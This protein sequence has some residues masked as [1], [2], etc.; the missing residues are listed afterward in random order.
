MIGSYI[1]NYSIYRLIYAIFGLFLC[2]LL[3]GWGSMVTTLEAG[4]AVPDWPTSF[5]SY[6]PFNP[7]FS[8]PENPSLKWWEDT[9]VMVEHVHRL[10][11]ALVGLWTIGLAVWTYIADPRRWMKITAT[12]AVALVVIQGLLG[13]LR[14]LWTS[15]DLAVAHAM[16]AQIF[17]CTASILA[18]S[19]SK[20][21]F[22]HTLSENAGIDTVRVLA[23]FTAGSVLIQILLGALL[24]H[25]GA[26]IDTNFIIVH[27]LGGIIALSFIILTYS[28]IR[29]YFPFI[30]LFYAGAFWILYTAIFQIL[31]GVASLIAVKYDSG[32]NQIGFWQ[33]TSTS[34]HVVFGS[35]LMGACACI[36]AG[37][38]KS[39]LER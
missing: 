5:G 37:T 7:G 14:V 28:Y 35:L 4:L 24:R 9:G 27:V 36:I 1:E 30:H 12:I 39:K 23:F 2:L 17:F 33:V 29:E 3:I 16:G 11:G 21:W 26:G 38:L 13:G 31:L 22:Q 32:L 20:L 34:N 19:N 10:L 18:L 6:D 15:L 25:P 8:D